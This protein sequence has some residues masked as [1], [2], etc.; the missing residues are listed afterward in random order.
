MQKTKKKSIVVLFVL[1]AVIATVCIIN[2]Q[3]MQVLFIF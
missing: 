2:R 1:I 3:K